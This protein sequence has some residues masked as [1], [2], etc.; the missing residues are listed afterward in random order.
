ML[1]AAAL[2]QVAQLVDEDKR[3]DQRGEH[4]AQAHKGGKAAASARVV[5][6][7]ALRV[8]KGGQLALAETIEGQPCT[9]KGRESK[10]GKL[11]TSCR[12]RGGRGPPK[13][14]AILLLRWLRW[15]DVALAFPH[16]AM[17][18]AACDALRGH[19]PAVPSVA[20]CG[21]PRSSRHKIGKAAPSKR[22]E[23]AD[24]ELAEDGRRAARAEG[25]EGE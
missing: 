17:A 22:G 3:F 13:T 5:S 14:L 2:V 10:L 1:T 20:T 25:R 18:T 8:R 7:V 9:L 15:R 24:E 6:A 12:K 19:C 16:L 4:G 21:D 23:E 11:Q